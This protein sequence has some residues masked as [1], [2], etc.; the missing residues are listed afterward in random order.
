MVRRCCPELDLEAE[1]AAAAAPAEAAPPAS[2]PPPTWWHKLTS[3]PP[4]TEPSDTVGQAVGGSGG[5][6]EGGGFSFAFA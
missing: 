3:A 1:L 6:A 4:S 5:D 2:A